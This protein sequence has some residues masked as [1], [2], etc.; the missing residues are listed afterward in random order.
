[1]ARQQLTYTDEQLDRYFSLLNLPK[2]H[3]TYCYEKNGLD[4]LGL[5][6]TLIRAQLARIPFEC[7]DLHYTA[8]KT[9]NLGHNYLFAKFVDAGGHRG[10]YC[11]ENNLF[12]SIVLRSL[13]FDVIT[14]GGR[15][16][17]AAVSV[18]AKNR[19]SSSEFRG[20]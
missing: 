9:I 12:F 15:V 13:G 14:V 4:R 1:M 6:N 19:D 3:R 18:E 2:Y 10:G 17:K 20:W 11:L 7:L 16:N 5:L 8:S